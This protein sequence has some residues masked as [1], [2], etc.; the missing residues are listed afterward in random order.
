MGIY[1]FYYELVSE[2]VFMLLEHSNIISVL[3]GNNKSIGRKCITKG[4]NTIFG[5]PLYL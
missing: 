4:Y 3:L 5:F 1:G 2:N